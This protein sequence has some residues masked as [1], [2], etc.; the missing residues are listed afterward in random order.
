M[1]KT[2]NISVILAT[3]VL[4]SSYCSMQKRHYR[5]GFTIQ[6]FKKQKYLKKSEKL[7]LSEKANSGREIKEMQ[8][9]G[10]ELA[11]DVFLR[12]DNQ[13]FINTQKLKAASFSLTNGGKFRFLES[14]SNSKEFHEQNPEEQNETSLVDSQKKRKKNWLGSL[15]GLFGAFGFFS[16]LAGII[17]TGQEVASSLILGLGVIAP[18]LLIG[19]GLMLTAGSFFLLRRRKNKE[20]RNSTLVNQILGYV[21]AAAYFVMVYGFEIFSEFAFPAGWA[22]L[23]QV[24]MIALSMGIAGALLLN[25]VALFMRVGKGK[26]KRID[27]E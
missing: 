24:G 19:L 5:N 7:N 27:S 22:A 1:N 6:L 18:P 16:F 25:L 17:L 26:G 2:I 11:V 8:F 9:Y 14:E 12:S 23:A 20:A 15:G 3:F 13:V 10:N 21:T 4:L